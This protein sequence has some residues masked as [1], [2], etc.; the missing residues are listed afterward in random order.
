MPCRG[1][2]CVPTVISGGVD[3]SE[4]PGCHLLRQMSSQ[5]ESQKLLEGL[6]SHELT[7]YLLAFNLFLT[8]WIMIISSKR[9]KPDNIEPHNSPKR[10]FT[11][12]WGLRSHFVKCVSFLESNPPNILALYEKNL[13][14]LI[15]SANFSVRVYLP[16]IRK[17]SNTHIHGLA[18]Y[19]K[20]W[21]LF[22][23]DLSYKTL[24]ILTYVF[25]WLCFTRC[26]TSS[27]SIDHII[28]CYARF[29]ALFH[30]T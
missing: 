27:S 30:R 26:L 17:D 6:V 4:V 25:D 12:I 24:R 16:L 1:W 10:S 19:V 15:D 3:I 21:L 9:C 2:K 22:A 11:N 18:V 8:E 29:L 5:W 20:E 28:R 7:A 13:N 23:S 14:D